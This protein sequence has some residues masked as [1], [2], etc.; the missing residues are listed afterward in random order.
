MKINWINEKEVLEN[1][2]KEGVPYS[3]IGKRYGVT[4][5]SV[6]KA[7]KKLGIKLEYRR[8]I[9]PNE[10][11]NKGQN[12][13]INKTVICLNCGKEFT[14][15]RGSFGKFCCIQCHKDFQHKEY[16]ER[17]KNGEEN[18]IKGEYGLSKH[19]RKYIFEKNECKC[20]KCGWGEKNEFTGTIPLEIHHI[21]SNYANNSEEN[22]QLLCP[23]CHSLTETHKSHNKKGRVGRKRY[24]KN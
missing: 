11:F 20:E 19:I 9:N 5:A 10:H 8:S 14:P 13:N 22:L 16:I 3:H 15:N 23:N 12:K 17:W 24:S 7:A 1:L 18:G 6:K 21:D 4:G 2:I